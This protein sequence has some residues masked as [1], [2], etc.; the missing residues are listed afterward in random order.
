MTDY[1]EAQPPLT[2]AE[3]ARVLYDAYRNGCWWMPAWSSKCHRTKDRW[4]RLAR[5][6]KINRC[7]FLGESLIEKGGA[8]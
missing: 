2:D 6:L 3:L 1:Y 4:V 8:K 7:L 5:E